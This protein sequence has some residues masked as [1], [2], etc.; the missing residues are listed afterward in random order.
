MPETTPTSSQDRGPE[1]FTLA[2]IQHLTRVEFSRAQRYGYPLVCLMIGVDRLEHVRDRLGYD[3]KQI[4]MDRVVELLGRETRTS[5]FI[6]RLPDDRFLIVVPHARL[7]RI[8]VLAARLLAAAREL[9]LAQL[10]HDL[11]LSLSIGGSWLA[12][13]E[14]IF[15]DDLLHAA[16]ECLERAAAEGGDC[17]V[18]RAPGVERR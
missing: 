16:E 6:G 2:Q 12:E 15:F 8:E 18:A 11:A 3:A 9:D 10:E 17:Y 14:T 13:G 5:D 7:D 4:V 1:I